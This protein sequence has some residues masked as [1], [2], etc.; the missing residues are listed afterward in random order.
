MFETLRAAPW[1]YPAPGWEGP[2]EEQELLQEFWPALFEARL[3]G[4]APAEFL[5]G[6]C[7]TS[8]PYGIVRRVRELVAPDIIRRRRYVTSSSMTTV[9]TLPSASVTV[10]SVTVNLYG[11]FGD[12][13]VGVPLIAPVLASNARPAGSVSDSHL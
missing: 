3:I 2:D 4:W 1:V 5:N 10:K 8:T 9:A 6:M 13:V 11:F 12:V 7:W